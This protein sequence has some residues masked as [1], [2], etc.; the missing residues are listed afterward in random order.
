MFDL[1]YDVIANSVPK[2]CNEALENYYELHNTTMLKD[3]PKLY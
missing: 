1:K 3:M 2:L